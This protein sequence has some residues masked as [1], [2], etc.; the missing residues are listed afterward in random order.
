[1][2]DMSDI[3]KREVVGRVGNPGNTTLKRKDEHIHVYN[4]PITD[5]R[6]K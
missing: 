6:T 1:M 5:L 3:L 4:M 2:K